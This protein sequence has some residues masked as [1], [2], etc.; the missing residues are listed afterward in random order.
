MTHVR[1]TCFGGLLRPA[2]LCLANYGTLADFKYLA[3]HGVSV[4]G[5]IV[6]VRYGVD[7]R[8]IKVYIA[9]Q[10][11]A[12]GVLIYSDPSDDGYF[13]RRQPTLVGLTV[14]S[15]QVQRG[16]TQFLPIYPGD[17]ETPRR[18]VHARP[19]DSKRQMNPANAS[20]RLAQQFRSIRSPTATLHQFCTPWL[21]RTRLVRGR[22]R[23]S[24]PTMS[25]PM[26]P[27]PR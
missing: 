15:R 10:Y 8:G 26:L 6:L 5:K 7:F 2:L 23:C 19:F 16:S 14:Q 27:T 12:A 11:G 25:A 9:Q 3:A 18:R 17:P 21:A 1:L 4:K 20:V 22:E 24:S 13:R